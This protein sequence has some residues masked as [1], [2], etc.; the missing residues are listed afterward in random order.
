MTYYDVLQ[1]SRGA[2]RDVIEA[3]WKTLMLVHHPDKGGSQKTAQ[4]INEAHDVLSNPAKRAVYDAQILR[5]ERR[6]DRMPKQPPPA[7]AGCP[8]PYPPP[9]P[10]LN[11]D[12]FNLSEPMRGVADALAAE[13]REAVDRANVAALEAIASRN[14]LLRAVIDQFVRAEKKKRR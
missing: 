7:A 9:Y 10:G 11:L 12:S 14:P 2:S 13:I 8:P 4:L 6:A 1:V 5:G 3:A